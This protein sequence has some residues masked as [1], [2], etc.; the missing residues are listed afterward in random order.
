MYDFTKFA[1]LPDDR[2]ERRT[3][4]LAM[5]ADVATTK[6]DRSDYQLYLIALINQCLFDDG[7][8]AGFIELMRDDGDLDALAKCY[9]Y[10]ALDLDEGDDVDWDDIHEKELRDLMP[11]PTREL[12]A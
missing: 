1:E 10:T 11:R 6:Y 5:L 3:M 2:N 7:D 4:L 8:S 9:G 12:A